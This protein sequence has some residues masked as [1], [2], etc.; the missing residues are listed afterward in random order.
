[1]N[2]FTIAHVLVSQASHIQLEE[3]RAALRCAMLQMTQE[4]ARSWLCVCS[5]I[6]IIVQREVTWNHFSRIQL[7]FEFAVFV[8]G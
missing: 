4:V 6:K 3:A 8:T 2:V 5:A 1:M 7:M